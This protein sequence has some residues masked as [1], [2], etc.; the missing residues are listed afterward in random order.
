MFIPEGEALTFGEMAP[1][2]KHAI[3]HRAEAFARLIA[4]CLPPAGR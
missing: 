3:S 1:E 4:A 2:D